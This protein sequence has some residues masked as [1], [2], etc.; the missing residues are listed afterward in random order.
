MV[1]DALPTVMHTDDDRAGLARALV[2]LG[3]GM[4]RG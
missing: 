1:V 3:E 2:R 4:L